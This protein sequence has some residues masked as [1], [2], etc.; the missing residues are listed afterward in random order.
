MLRFRN[1]NDREAFDQ[2]VHRFERELYSYLRRYLS[3]AELARDV[4]QAT[5]LR[6]YQ[7]SD[8]YEEGR[9]VRPWLY[10]IAT[11][12]AIDAMRKA[13]RE[14]ALSI[15]RERAGS[16]VDSGEAGTLLDVLQSDTPGPVREA[17]EHE[18]R[19]RAR[20][21]VDELP[22]DLRAVVLL[23][24]FQGLKYSEAAD[25]LNIPI[26]TVKSRM[27]SALAQLNRRWQQSA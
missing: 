8:L 27:H 12:L 2:L 23:V 1:A 6:V 20:R 16:A 18:L 3:D 24:F 4:F 10:S 26:G 25:A 19:D 11:H 15:E 9:R 21:A 13:G 5:F 7:K 22:R 17:E 14:R